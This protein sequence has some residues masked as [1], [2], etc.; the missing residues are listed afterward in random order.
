MSEAPESN[1]APARKPLKRSESHAREERIRRKTID[2][3]FRLR[4]QKIV[5]EKQAQK[6][7]NISEVYIYLTQGD[8]NGSKTKELNKILELLQKAKG[9]TLTPLLSR[10]MTL[11]KRGANIEPALPKILPFLLSE[12]ELI[13]EAAWT[14][15]SRVSPSSEKLRTLLLDEDNKNGLLGVFK[16]ISLSSASVKAIAA[17]LAQE[18][19]FWLDEKPIQ[20]EEHIIEAFVC[21]IGCGYPDVQIQALDILYKQAY[22]KMSIQELCYDQG[23]VDTIYTLITSNSPIDVQT[24]TCRLIVALCSGNSNVKRRMRE[25]QILLEVVEVLKNQNGGELMKYAAL[26]LAEMCVED[27]ESRLVVADKGVIDVLINMLKDEESVATVAAYSID[28]LVSR[29]GT[30]QSLFTNTEVIQLLLD[31]VRFRCYVLIANKYAS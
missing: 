28:S 22:A 12:H 15:L 19:L 11:A 26:A 20:A 21:A 2:L 16:G 5:M 31:L 10:V 27:R 23:I 29:D 8:T 18:V 24:K 9:S 30:M 14:L 25:K 17:N 3:E 4:E 13:A 6:K 1:P 7:V